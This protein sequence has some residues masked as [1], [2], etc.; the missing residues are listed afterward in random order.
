MLSMSILGGYDMPYYAQAP[1]GPT[2]QDTAATK[3]PHLG[4]Y[5]AYLW[6]LMLQVPTFPGCRRTPALLA[7]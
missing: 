5:V 3:G 7:H 6:H 4:G 1:Q 2:V